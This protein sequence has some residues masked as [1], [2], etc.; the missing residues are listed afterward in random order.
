MPKRSREESSTSESE[1][2]EVDQ[3]EEVVDQ[4]EEV[5]E[6]NLTEEVE[7]DLM[8][9]H[10]FQSEPLEFQVDPIID[11]LRMDAEETG[12]A[13][14]GL[15]PG[16][17]KTFIALAGATLSRA[18]QGSHHPSLFV[19]L[20]NCQ[21]TVLE[22]FAKH[23][24]DT[25]EEG[26]LFLY[27]KKNR[28]C[29][30]NNEK[31]E[32]MI[33]SRFVLTT[34]E[35]VTSEHQAYQKAQEAARNRLRSTRGKQEG[36]PEEPAL[37]AIQWNF[38]IFDE[39]LM[40]LKNSASVCF[41]ACKL[42]EGSFRLALCSDFD[43]AKMQQVISLA[44][45]LRLQGYSSKK[46][47]K[48]FDP[49][50]FQERFTVSATVD[51]LETDDVKAPVPIRHQIELTDMEKEGDALWATKFAAVM[52]DDNMTK[53]TKALTLRALITHMQESSCDG[54]LAKYGRAAV[55]QQAVSL[56]DAQ[57][58][59]IQTATCRICK[60]QTAPRTSVY[61]D[62]C[63]HVEH[64]DCR[65]GKQDDDEC[66]F[67]NEVSTYVPSKTEAVIDIIRN[68]MP[69]EEKVVVIGHT[70]AS[71][72]LL[73][74]HLCNEGVRVIRIDSQTTPV[75][76]KKKKVEFEE[77]DGSCVLLL[78]KNIGGVGWN[79]HNACS[80]LIVL[81]PCWDQ[82]ERQQIIGRLYRYG[83]K[84]PVSVW[85]IVTNGKIDKYLKEEDEGSDGTTESEIVRCA[86]L[87]E[88]IA[89]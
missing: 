27:D 88:L 81:S 3:D 2:E 38:V 61:Q 71:F 67:C 53:N 17:G 23:T 73:E 33:T 43:M 18:A 86:R 77:S 10:E 55:V 82:K 54:V 51:V 75:N 30:T 28:S 56:T 9:E 6:R 16:V 41:K 72:D 76:R 42:F 62:V 58:K 89:N 45:I 87:A 59:K 1:I 70:D 65:D 37:F 7:N 44:M 22:E 31:L 60:Q 39:A 35:D 66:E 47:F 19:T 85:E 52:H 34:Y 68:H 8:A 25:L 46:D 64:E 40:K 5:V 4:E 69:D 26:R 79:L 74:H 84:K 50:A 21:D 24:G 29:L 12:G 32:R 20:S 63:G 80:N 78:S 57:K 11:I 13:I 48:D 83:Q 15:Q 36:T 49:E 14:V